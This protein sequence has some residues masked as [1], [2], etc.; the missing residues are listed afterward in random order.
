MSDEQKKHSLNFSL[1]ENNMAI[2]KLR[3]KID[4]AEDAI[5][6]GKRIEYKNASSFAEDVIQRGEKSLNH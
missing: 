1:N 2:Q 4:I 5:Q 6:K 3:A